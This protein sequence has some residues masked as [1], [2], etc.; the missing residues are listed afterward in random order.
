VK[1]P[2]IIA[3]LVGCAAM[4]T[5]LMLFGVPVDLVLAKVFYDPEQHKFLAATNPYVAE[6]RDNGL[7]ALTTC[8]AVVAAAV[9]PRFMKRPIRFIPT[10]VAVFLAGTLLL[11]SGF[12]ANLVLKEHWHRPRPVHVTEF[13]G[14]KIYVDGWNRG[15]G[16]ARNCSFVSGEA[17]SAAWMFAPAM[18]APPHYRVAAYIGAGLFTAVI[19]VSRMAAGGHFFTDVVFAILFMLLII[20]TAYRLIF[21][22]RAASSVA[23]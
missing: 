9:A 20:V 8:L 2:Y 4:A 12:L 14:D 15:G 22:P 7:I 18:L 21:G 6:L 1:V 16:C 11:G 5:L 10:R 13:G 17:S 3:P 19:G 23:K